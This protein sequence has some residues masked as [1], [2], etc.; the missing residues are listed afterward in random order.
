MTMYADIQVTIVHKADKAAKPTYTPAFINAE[1]ISLMTKADASER[2]G[3]SIIQ[4]R[5]G[6]VLRVM[7]SVYQL[8]WLRYKASRKR[9]GFV[10]YDSRRD[11]PECKAWLNERFTPRE[12]TEYGQFLREHDPYTFGEQPTEDDLEALRGRDREGDTGRSLDAEMEQ[13]DERDRALMYINHSLRHGIKLIW[14]GDALEVYNEPGSKEFVPLTNAEK[15]S[16][17]DLLDKWQ[18]WD[19]FSDMKDKPQTP[20]CA[21]ADHIENARKRQ[22]LLDSRDQTD[23]TPH[24]ES[25]KGREQEA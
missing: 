23:L 14:R 16:L 4:M 1:D 13:E 7:Q 25:I 5:T 2:L 24:P 21:V 22:E 11:D 18:S 10:S 3:Y 9:A 15:Q 12:E 17:Q 19:M 8:Q 20:W 6:K